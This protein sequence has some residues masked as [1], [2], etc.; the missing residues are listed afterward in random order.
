M[1]KKTVTVSIKPVDA[2]YWHSVKQFAMHRHMTLKTLVHV[3]IDQYMARYERKE[4]RKAK[5]D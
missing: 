1:P 4:R 2:E 3:A 5:E